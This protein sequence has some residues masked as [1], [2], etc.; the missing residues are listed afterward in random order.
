MKGFVIILCAITLGYSLI[1]YVFDR[2]QYLTDHMFNTYV[3]LFGQIDSDEYSASQ[4][5]L[6]AL[7]LFLLSIVLLNLLISIMGDS[8]D[9]VQE[10]RVLTDSQTRLDM[11]LETNILRRQISRKKTDEKGYLIFC[12]QGDEEEDDPL[13]NEWEGRVNVMKK[14]LKVSSQRLE[15]KIEEEIEYRKREFKELAKKVAGSEVMITHQFAAIEQKFMC[16]VAE[17]K[18]RISTLEDNV[19]KNHLEIIET[20]KALSSNN[21]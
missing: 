17:V 4:K 5:I 19:Q 20:L 2:T 14:M 11:I 15:S 10:R 13:N 9:K 18:Q 6:L 21:S 16:E 1:F 3:L 8:F 7:V 12:E